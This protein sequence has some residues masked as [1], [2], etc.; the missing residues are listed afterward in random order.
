MSLSFFPDG[1]GTSTYVSQLD[2]DLGVQVDSAFYPT[3]R[4]DEVLLPKSFRID[5]H[6]IIW[7]T[8]SPSL[9]EDVNH[10]ERIQKL[11]GNWPLSSPLRREIAAAGELADG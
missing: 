5:F 4:H 9:V 1:P 7:G 10:P 6:S 2:K 8:G 11:A 3:A